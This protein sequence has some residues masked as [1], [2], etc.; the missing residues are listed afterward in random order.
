MITAIERQW[1]ILA[2]GFCFACF[3]LGGVFLTVFV[4]PTIRLITPA[5]SAVTCR[6]V[7]RR[8]FTLF[9][10]LMTRVGVIRFEIAGAQILARDSG[11]LLVANHP[12]LIDYIVIASLTNHCDCIV[13]QALWSNP[14][15]HGVVKAAGY[16]PN[17]GAEEV[18]DSCWKSLRQGNVLMIFPEGTRTASD[19]TPRLQRGAANIALRTETPIR[20]IHIQCEPQTLTKGEK[21]YQAPLRRPVYQLRVGELVDVSEFRNTATSMPGSARHLTDYLQTQLSRGI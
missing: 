1:R 8:S 6:R 12:T 10:W 15:L 21:W 2:T 19:T 16:I 11:C 7:I 9:M 14:F 20:V 18:I 17:K 13:K 5:R 3:G 4:F